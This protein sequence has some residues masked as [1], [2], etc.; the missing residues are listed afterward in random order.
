M[1]SVTIE[2]MRNKLTSIADE[3]QTVLLKAAFSP[4]VKEGMDASSAIF[5]TKGQ[6]IAQAAA[7][8]LHLG[9]LIP[10]IN[11]IIE[12]WNPEEMEKDDM[13]IL[14][15]PYN[16]GTHLPD[17]V[18][19]MPVFHDDKPFAIVT[20]MCHHQ[21]MGGMVP[22]SLPPDSTELFQEGLRIPPMQYMS[23]GKII[24][25]IKQMIAAN[26][27]IPDIVLGDINAQI[28]ALRIGERRMKELVDDVGL[29]IFNQ[30][31]DELM[32]RSEIMTRERIKDIPDGT[33]SFT[34]YIDDDGIGN[35]VNI[36]IKATITI[37]DDQL[38]VDFTGTSSQLKGPYN[39]VPSS[40]I[41]A[42]YYVVRSVTGADIP[43]NSGCFRSITI[44]LPKKSLV[45]PDFPA[46]V[47]SRTASVKRIS[48]ALFGCFVQAIPE[49]MPA[50]ACG[51]L[52]VMNF[53]GY[54]PMTKKTYITSELGM[55][56]TGGRPMKDGVSSIDTDATNCMNILAEPLEM[57]SPIRIKRWRLWT[58][59]AGAGTWRGGLG[60]EKVFEVVR[61]SVTI[62]Y[63]GER[64]TTQPWG[65]NGGLA[66]PSSRAYVLRKNSRKEVVKS[67]QVIYLNEGDQ[68]Q[69]FISGG[70][71]YGSPLCRPIDLVQEDLKNNYISKESAEN[72][73]GIIFDQEGNIDIE[74]TEKNR[75][76]K[77]EKSIGKENIIHRGGLA[78]WES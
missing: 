67:K 54:D 52:L 19:A 56:G 60:I 17:I 32:D 68:L 25:P 74:S 49:K 53:G 16:G 6:T 55:G 5:D 34:D 22:G 33:Y 43:N 27:R 40:T 3:M 24:E 36:P 69:V 62:T 29:D 63:R 4:I 26:V 13:F 76:K 20:T 70:G 37:D 12:I 23:K 31:I 58:D 38:H 9:C 71:G 73:Y 77:L 51:Q 45:N 57:E 39:C 30:S 61:G 42:V 65:V 2:I 18:L 59:S 7:I 35:E 28:S 10:A 72:L 50:A 8:P 47:N 78:P 11:K 1:D 41:S 15:D 14:N 64:H 75:K 44:H 21:E 46:P 48:D 66:A